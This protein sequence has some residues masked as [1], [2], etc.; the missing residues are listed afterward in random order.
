MPRNIEGKLLFITGVSAGFGRAFSKA[1]LEVGHRVVGT[2][3]NPQHVA[4]FEA[5]VDSEHASLIAP[6]TDGMRK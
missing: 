1:A 6:C 4:S 2:V 3:R 5:Q